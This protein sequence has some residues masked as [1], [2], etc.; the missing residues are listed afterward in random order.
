MLYELSNVETLRGALGLSVDWARYWQEPDET[1]RMLE[2]PDFVGP[3]RAVAAQVA[4]AP[5]AQW[6]WDPA[7]PEQFVTH[8]FETDPYTR[9]EREPRPLDPTTIPAD[10]ERWKRE[11]DADEVSFRESREADPASR[12]SGAWWSL[13]QYVGVWSSPA[14][15]RLG[16]AALHFVEDGMDF[17]HARVWPVSVRPGARIVEID[18][19]D[20]WAELCRRHPFDVSESRRTVWEW[21][22][23]RDGRWVLPDWPAVAREWD[24]VHVTGAGY[25]RTAGRAIAV[26]GETA[27]VLAGWEPGQT[28]WLTDAFEVTGPAVEWVAEPADDCGFDWK[29]IG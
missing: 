3:L 23:G 24:A 21:T 2:E 29:P 16:P 10:L 26:D 14:L 4:A 20:A 13:P 8:W 27:T 12:V 5:E 17:T 9:R 19:P 11:A 22:T 15:G 6:L 7:A 25:L 1:D 18:G 28:A